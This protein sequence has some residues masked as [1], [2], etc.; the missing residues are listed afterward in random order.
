MAAF[1]LVVVARHPLHVYLHFDHSLHFLGKDQP[2]HPFNPT[3]I[4]VTELSSE[5]NKCAHGKMTNTKQTATK[6]TPKQSSGE[7]EAL[8]SA[9]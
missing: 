9:I 8:V 5:H 4:Y 6:Q 1:R 2:F 3:C 7:T